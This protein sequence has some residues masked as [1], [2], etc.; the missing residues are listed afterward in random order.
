MTT[1][2]LLD[3]TNKLKLSVPRTI[4]A[5]SKCL[6][7]VLIM[8]SP[9]YS[10]ISTAIT[11]NFDWVPL[12]QLTEAQRKQLSPGC[13]G[14]YIAPINHNTRL[15]INQSP[16]EIQADTSSTDRDATVLLEGHV[17]VS[18][19]TRELK[20]D[21]AT[22][23]QT[24]REITLKGNIF[25]REEGLLIHAESAALAL[26]TKNATMHD[27]EFV[28]HQSRIHGKAVQ[29]QKFSERLIH[30]TDA[31]ITT[32]A[33]DDEFWQL[34]ASAIDIHTDESYGT[35][36]NITLKLK[37]IPIFYL[38]YMRF[39]VGKARQT[40]LLYPAAS[41]SSQNGTEYSQAFYWNI[42]PNAD[43]TLTPHYMSKRGIVWNTD[44]R[45]KTSVFDTAF[46]G[47]YLSNDKGGDEQGIDTQQNSN[48]TYKN[49]DRWYVAFTQKGVLTERLST[50]ID[51]TDLSDNQYLL[52]IN[53]GN[54]DLNRQALTKKMASIHYAGSTWSIG[55]RAQEFRALN[56]SRQKPYRELPRLYANGHFDFDNWSMK[57]EH[58]YT[59][60]D[61]TSLYQAS[62]DALVEGGRFRTD[63]GISWSKQWMAGFIKPEIGYKTLS[64]QLEQH[65]PSVDQPVI[66]DRN[67]HITAPFA[68]LDMG[69]L[70]E[71]EGSLG[72]SQYIQTLEPHLFYSYS[73][74][75]NHQAIYNP[76]ND[77]NQPVNFDTTYLTFNYNQLFRNTRFSGGDRIDDANQ[78]A[79]GMTTRFISPDT[80][81][82]RL[83][84][85]LGQIYR[86]EES[87]VVLNP[88][89]ESLQLA[90]G[91][92]Q[93]ALQ[94]N[95]LLGKG[96][97]V[98]SDVLYD[99][100]SHGIA[101]ASASIHYISEDY[102]LV[103]VAYRYQ[104]ALV[105]SYSGV[106]N[107]EVKQLDASLF[108]PISASWSIIAR[109]N[110]DFE[111]KRELDT[112]TGFEYN[113]C[114]YR[115]RVLWR[116]W[117][118]LDYNASNS[119]TAIASNDYETGFFFDL[120]LKGLGDISKRVGDLLG[121]TIMGYQTREQHLP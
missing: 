93:Y 42:A 13:C 71:R 8:L 7:F 89:E 41:H 21:Q 109:S 92:S 39:P 64:Y 3:L 80:G 107:Q 5:H 68:S 54:I 108:L 31:S 49:E 17:E 73:N 75:S 69:M 66:Y 50:E 94:V 81:I 33:P 79:A 62:T 83:R 52:D 19:G 102:K 61:I 70:F 46:T 114:C 15:P 6:C 103:N 22:I 90:K 63:Y 120:Q 12:E 78:I 37:N 58:E 40:G 28:L 67:P 111:H 101:N 51:Y 117:L 77:S 56:E 65:N 57:A 30:L 74:P 100:D 47:G 121:Q 116:R 105:S 82:E 25:V 32:C 55:G 1:T 98:S 16:I 113:D 14:A 36:E 86:F 34:N 97:S 76:L 112:F 11:D 9:L 95:S 59:R 27:V 35:A 106:P 119:T 115:I 26:D 23:N 53:S 84:I 4:Y 43:L 45:H 72:E 88:A 38:P 29:L 85:S 44:V 24:T 48:D 20:A 96:V 110:Y 104:D 18:Q 10:Q 60:F 91:S 2:P 118:D 87:T 99:Q